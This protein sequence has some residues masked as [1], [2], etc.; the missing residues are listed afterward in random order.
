MTCPRNINALGFCLFQVKHSREF[1]V[2]LLPKQNQK[3]QI[4]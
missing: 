1:C 2:L 4:T 3:K